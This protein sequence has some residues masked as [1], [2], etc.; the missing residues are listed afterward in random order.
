M[1][2]DD[3][4]MVNYYE[5]V[6][7]AAAERKLIVDFHGAFKPSGLRMRY[8]NVLTYEGVMGLEHNKW[9]K[10]VTPRHDLLIPFIRMFAGPMDYTPGA[11]NN[12][13]EKNFKPIFNRPM[14][15][16]TRCHQL[17]MF[18]CYESPLQMLCDAPSNYYREPEAMEFLS[19]VPSVWD[20][21]VVLQ[22]KVSD[23]LVVARR[24]GKKWFV[25]GMGDWNEHELEIGFSFLD[26]GK[27]YKM[28]IVQ[29]GINAN[30]IATDFKRIE[31][32]VS[33]DDTM[34][35]KMKKGGGWVA[36]IIPED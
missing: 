18:V 25:G 23:Y 17:A 8:P 3:Q 11:M 13:Q 28:V 27:K 7:E 34:T 26:P 21:T 31:K 1:Q 14:S 33:S 32:E 2:R 35:I 16:G 15:M 36:Q 22:A 9:S 10:D 4:W 29:D 20:E 19:A 24:S 6:A 30:R 5:R 12:A